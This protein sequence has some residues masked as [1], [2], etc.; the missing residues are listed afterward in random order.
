MATLLDNFFYERE[1]ETA[2]TRS[3]NLF[4]RDNV[5]GYEYITYL[6]DL[7]DLY[8]KI[9]DLLLDYASTEEKKESSL[10]NIEYLERRKESTIKEIEQLRHSNLGYTPSLVGMG[11]DKFR[12]KN[13]LCGIKL[14][15]DTLDNLNRSIFKED[16]LHS[17]SLRKIDVIKSILLR[18]YTEL[19]NTYDFNMLDKMVIGTSSDDVKLLSVLFKRRNNDHKESDY[20]ADETYKL[21]LEELDYLIDIYKL[22]ESLSFSEL[23]KEKIQELR[24]NRM[25]MKNIKEVIELKRDVLEHLYFIA[26]SQK[27]IS[28]IFRSQRKTYGSKAIMNYAD[29]YLDAYKKNEL[30]EL[31]HQTT[32]FMIEGVSSERLTSEEKGYAKRLFQTYVENNHINKK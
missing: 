9:V 13:S 26:V 31:D 15:Y 27:D 2:Y 10:K 32:E 14:K 30:K 21:F 28:P 3:V 6:Y 29:I 12:L 19:I 4:L 5:T 23:T 7:E 20:L 8:T 11:N 17:S 22:T 1:T 24:Q 18:K 16:L 25:R